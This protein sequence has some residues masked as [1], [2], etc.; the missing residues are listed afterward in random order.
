M[1]LE[2]SACRPGWPMPRHAVKHRQPP[3]R[4]APPI[5]SLGQRA[6][7]CLP[8]PDPLPSRRA[9]FRNQCQQPECLEQEQQRDQQ[10]WP[11]PHSQRIYPSS[12]RLFGTWN[13]SSNGA[14]EAGRAQG[15]R[16]SRLPPR[17]GRGSPA[18]SCLLHVICTVSIAFRR[19]QRSCPAWPTLNDPTSRLQAALLPALP[20]DHHPGRRSQPQGQRARGCV[21][22]ACRRLAAAA[23]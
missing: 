12:Y 18:A 15:G 5:S 11:R 20:P 2:P 6:G 17:R 22:A 7:R 8:L 23:F 1:G 14:G 4:G 21:P 10:R 13:S 3:A 16:A 19:A 9:V